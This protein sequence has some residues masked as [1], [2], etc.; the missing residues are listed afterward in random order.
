MLRVAL[1]KGRLLDSFIDYLQR[2]K[3]KDMSEALLSRKR[4]LLLTVDSIEFIL[5]KGSDVPTYVEQG[6]ADVGIVG[7]DVLN[8][9]KFNINNLLDLPFGKCH[10]A[11]LLNLKRRRT[12]SSDELCSYGHTVLCQ[13]RNGC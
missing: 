11:L 3:Q 1:A 6:I 9:H 7:S 5:V 13:P 2:V 4:L 10:F 8:E 12:K